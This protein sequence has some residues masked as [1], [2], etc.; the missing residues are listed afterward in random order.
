MDIL[1][2]H[3]ISFNNIGFQLF[4]ELEKDL[5]RVLNERKHWYLPLPRHW[6]ADVR[7]KSVDLEAK[8]ELERLVEQQK[9]LLGERQAL[10]S[11]CLRISRAPF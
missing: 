9:E 4:A 7:F 11:I 1:G 10:V 2:R 5:S 3:R 8:V 6:S